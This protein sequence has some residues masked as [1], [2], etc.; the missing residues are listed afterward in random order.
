MASQ[1]HETAFQWGRLN[2]RTINRMNFYVS[3]FVFGTGL[4]LFIRFHVGNGAYQQEWL[5]LE[6]YF[7]LFIHQATGTAFLA[8]FVW[9]IWTY[10]KY[11]TQ[12]VKRWRGNLSQRIKSRTLWQVVL[13]LTGI[14]VLWAGFYPWIAM[15]EATLE[16]KIYH[17]WIDVH[18]RVGLVF[19]A[20][21]STHIARRWRGIFR[22]NK[23][24]KV[25]QSNA[26]GKP[27]TER[28]N[29]Q[30][31]KETVRTGRKT[32]KY[33]IA[34]TSKCEAC[35]KCIEECEYDVLGNVNF[36]F[37]KHIF[38]KKADECRGCRKCV[39]ICPN[40]VF[41][42][43]AQKKRSSAMETDKVILGM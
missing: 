38:F 17:G 12:L 13:L 10:R 28:K 4:I 43:I 27:V 30:R 2:K 35:W 5:G 16:D 24:R 3:I 33:I 18:S 31:K 6:K 36:W 39:T 29:Q 8:G 40:D 22:M 11:I 41:A 19:L 20:G 7:W 9:H 37:H 42:P 25:A 15:P 26:S 14:V 23:R 21:L 32:T 34:D 1:L